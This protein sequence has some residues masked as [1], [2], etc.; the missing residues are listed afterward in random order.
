MFERLN[1]KVPQ[2]DYRLYEL[3]VLIEMFF[4]RFV[5]VG[6]L[7]KI[8]VGST[9]SLVNR[10]HVVTR[11]S[12]VTVARSVARLVAMVIGSMAMVTVATVVGSVVAETGLGVASEMK[13]WDGIIGSRPS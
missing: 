5:R 12:R 9:Q 1:L 4:V 7:D 13:G 3:I 2:R 11:S 6:R 10:R 8:Q